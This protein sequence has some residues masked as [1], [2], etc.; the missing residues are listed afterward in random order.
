[1]GNVYTLYL[2]VD[3]LR[4]HAFHCVGTWNKIHFDGIKK[5]TESYD[6]VNTTFLPER[7]YSEWKRG[8]S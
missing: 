3:F 6:L 7:T 5:M 8:K 4:L 2:F 1:M